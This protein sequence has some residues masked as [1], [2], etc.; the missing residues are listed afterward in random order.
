MLKPLI[1]AAG[2]AS[3]LLYLI[4]ITSSFKMKTEASPAFYKQV[5]ATVAV[6]EI[7]NTSDELFESWSL[8]ASGLSKDAFESA[9]TGYEKM[10]TK[11][12]ISKSI[13]AIIDFTKSS[14]QQ[15]LFIIDMTTGKLL[16]KSLVAHGHNSGNEFATKFSN[17]NESHQS[18]LGFYI[19]LNTYIG[20]HGYSLKLKG[21]EKGINDAAYQRAIV[22]HGADYV[23]DNTIKLKGYIGRSFGCPAVPAILDKKIVDLLKDGSCLFIFHPTQTYLTKSEILNG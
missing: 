10:K 15:R 14:A 21:C 18:S 13:L 11:G 23:S 22:I 4:F 17:E 3:A 8:S 6:P 20:E 19:T 7:K 9:F 2:L 16:L 1:R 5:V 12:T